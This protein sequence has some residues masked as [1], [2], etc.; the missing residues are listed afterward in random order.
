MDIGITLHLHADCT[1]PKSNLQRRVHCS[2]NVNNTHDLENPT[3]QRPHGQ[4]HQVRCDW[5]LWK[6]VNSGP[7]PHN[8]TGNQRWQWN[9]LIL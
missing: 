4:P 1:S 6:W 9:I 3:A 2:T 5:L 7:S 8:S